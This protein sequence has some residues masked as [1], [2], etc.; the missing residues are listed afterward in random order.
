MLSRWLSFGRALLELSSYRVRVFRMLLPARIAFF[1]SREVLIHAKQ[2][3]GREQKCHLSGVFNSFFLLTWRQNHSSANSYEYKFARITL[4]T[5]K[6]EQACRSEYDPIAYLLFACEQS[7]VAPQWTAQRIA[8]AFLLFDVFHWKLFFRRGIFSLLHIQW[9]SAAR[10][11]C[12]AESSIIDNDDGYDNDSW[13]CRCRHSLPFICL[14]VSHNTRSSQIQYAT[15]DSL[16]YLL[17]A[18]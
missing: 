12:R 8:I 14:L 17:I 4:R 5:A 11:T 6:A 18:I 7:P 9:H 2:A 15:M 1:T 3:G 10:H 16:A 13:T